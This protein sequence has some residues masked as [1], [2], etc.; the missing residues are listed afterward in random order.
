MTVLGEYILETVV[1]GGVRK[2]GNAD[3]EVNNKVNGSLNFGVET[4]VEHLRKQNAQLN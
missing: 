2:L 4:T 1:G 3:T